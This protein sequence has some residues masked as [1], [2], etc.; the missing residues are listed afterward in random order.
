MGVLFLL[1]GSAASLIY[2]AVMELATRTTGI[3]EVIPDEA[4]RSMR[5]EIW[6]KVWMSESIGGYLAASPSVLIALFKGTLWFVPFITLLIGFDQVS[7]DLQH[8]TIRYTAIRARRESI[9]AGKSLAI[10]GVVSTLLLG[11]HAFVWIITIVRG[12]GTLAEVASWGPRIWALTVV[13]SA[14]YSG[15]TILVSSLTKRPVISLF[16]GLI[17]FSTLWVI[18]LAVSFAKAAETERYW[19]QYIGYAIPDYYDAWLV[20]PKAPQ[21]IGGMVIL[22]TFGIAA[23][24]LASWIVRRRDI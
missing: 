9:I 10:W 6:S 21:M 17:W 5:E 14:A 16:L 20:T 15:L 1:G 23:T 4:I 22:L 19:I 7:G 3:D 12:N 8:R 24:A 2:A 13:Y 11:L 18:D